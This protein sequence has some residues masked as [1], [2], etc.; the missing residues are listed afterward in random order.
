MHLRD[1]VLQAKGL[2]QRICLWIDFVGGSKGVQ[3]ADIDIDGLWVTRTYATTGAAADAL[4]GIGI[5]HQNVNSGTIYALD[6]IGSVAGTGPYVD[7]SDERLKRDAVPID[8]ALQLVR[9]LD[10]VRFSWRDSGEADI[11]LLAQQ[12][13]AAVP[14]AA[15]QG[16]DGVWRVAYGRVVPLLLEAIKALDADADA[17]RRASRENQAA[18]ESMERRLE[19]LEAACPLSA[20]SARPESQ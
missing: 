8:D 2:T 10:G 9:A 6:V 17:A 19:A 3:T 7:V 12:V 5:H 1:E 4:K 15:V 14:E 13:A 11:G 20:P 16:D 18:L